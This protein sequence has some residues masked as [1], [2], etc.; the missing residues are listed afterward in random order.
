MLCLLQLVFWTQLLEAFNC[1]SLII[2][3]NNFIY[4]T[5]EQFLLNMTVI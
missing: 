3:F 1:F 2:V 4:F 5:T